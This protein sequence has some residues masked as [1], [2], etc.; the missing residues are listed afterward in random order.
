MSPQLSN[1][2]TTEASRAIGSSNVTDYPDTEYLNVTALT[3]GSDV[4]TNETTAPPPWRPLSGFDIPV[5]G[6]NNGR[7]YLIQGI[8]VACLVV[9]LTAALMALVLSFRR[10]SRGTFFTKWS[11]SERFIVY[12]ACCDGL[13]NVAHLL[14]HLHILVTK[15]HVYPKWLCSV[16]G[17][18]LAV[19]ITA[20][21]LLVNVVAVNAFL[22]IYYGKQLNFGTRDWKLLTWTFG[23]PIIAAIVA[24]AFDQYGPLG[25]G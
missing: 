7:F 8:A 24:A 13:F 5:Y 9:S 22:L 16:Y 20:Q 15:D 17:F 14:D 1:E 12:L 3:T 10:Q 19:F 23:V 2:T 25:G 21:N 18:N 11:K 4:T 6:L